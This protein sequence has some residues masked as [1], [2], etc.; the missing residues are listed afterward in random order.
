[1]IIIPAIDLKEGKCVRLYQGR[2]AEVTVYGEHPAEMALRWQKEGAEYLHIVDLDGAF[3]GEPRNLTALYDI[4]SA[5]TIPV[6]FGGGLRT[7]AAINQVFKKGVDRVILGT[8]ALTDSALLENAVREFGRR[9]FVGLDARKGKLAVEGWRTET[10]LRPVDLVDKLQEIGVGGIV[11]TDI[12]T[13]G[14]LSGPNF[15]ALDD[16]L[17]RTRMR[18]IASGGIADGEHIR[19]LATLGDGALYGAIVGKALYTGALTL[20]DILPIARSGDRS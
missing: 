18:V 3:R 1:M 17:A 16:L 8:A 2:E 6:E 5:V 14:T 15:K 10:G 19:R 20:A 12:L 9:V 13:D 4:L 11:Y 7:L